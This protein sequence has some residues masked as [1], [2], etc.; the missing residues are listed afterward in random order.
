MYGF[1]INTGDKTMNNRFT[2]VN[3]FIWK[4]WKTEKFQPIKYERLLLGAK[5]KENALRKY[6]FFKLLL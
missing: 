1:Y 5:Q 3:T 6:N 4:T 2:R